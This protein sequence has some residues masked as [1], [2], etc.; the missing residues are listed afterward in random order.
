[1][2]FFSGRKTESIELR[3]VEV[4]LLG[5]K[6][7]WV[8]DR[9]QQTAAW[10]LYVELV[11]RVALQQLPDDQGILREALD[12]L[13]SLFGETRRILRTHGPRVGRKLT[14]DSLAFASIA[15]YILNNVLRPLLTKWHPELQAHESRRQPGEAVYAH[16]MKWDETKRNELRKALNEVRPVLAEYANLLAAAAAVDPLHGSTKTSA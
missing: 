8:A 12:S 16:E 13:H 5:I 1:M 2:G 9:E 10:E 14:G 3:E 11:T 7:K 4:N 6:G 15:L